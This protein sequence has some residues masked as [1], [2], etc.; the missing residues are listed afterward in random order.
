V[1]IDAEVI[2]DFFVVVAELL[3]YLL[4]CCAIFHFDLMEKGT[5]VV[6]KW[7]TFAAKVFIVWKKWQ[8]LLQLP[9]YPGAKQ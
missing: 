6:A 8:I 1:S 4:Q 3:L 7:D 9:S 5:K 2:P